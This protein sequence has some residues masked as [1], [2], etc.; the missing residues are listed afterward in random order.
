M[1]KKISI[2]AGD[3]IEWAL[4]GYEDNRSG[5]LNE[6]C[7]RYQQ[8]MRD[9][10]PRWTEQEWC[11]V[12]DALNGY[13]MSGVSDEASLRLYWA[14][15]E[16]ADRLNGLGDKWGI[17]AQALAREIREL[18]MAGKIAV[19]EVVGRFWQAPQLQTTEALQQAGAALGQNQ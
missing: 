19:A 9:A 14:E 11:A 6:V 16:D 3:P 10:T 8:I 18:P 17:D 2:Y 5:R 12:C 15:I 13:W 7:S 1:G 4:R